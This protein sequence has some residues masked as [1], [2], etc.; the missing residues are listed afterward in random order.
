VILVDTSVWMDHFRLGSVALGSVL[1][2]A[3]AVTHPFVIGELACGNLN[4]R[5]EILADLQTLPQALSATQDEVLRLLDEHKLWT[6]GI[7][8]VDSHL[9]AS[10]LLSS[11]R[12]WTLDR[13][14]RRAAETAR[15]RLY[16]DK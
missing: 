15:A 7:G 1:E 3:Q 13:R 10:A 5:A 2:D 11:C 14:L 6:L 4:N 9:I 12:L 8:W 16:H